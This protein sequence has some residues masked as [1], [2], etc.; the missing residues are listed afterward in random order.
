SPLSIYFH[1][2]TMENVSLESVDQMLDNYN[3]QE[4]YEALSKMERSSE[5]EW[6]LANAIYFLSNDIEDAKERRAKITEG[7][8]FAKSAFEKDPSNAEAAKQA[9]ILV[10][11]LSEMASGSLEQMK[12]GAQFKKYLD[13]TIALNPEPDMVILH[14]RGRFSFAVASLSW[15]ERTMACK[16]LNSL[17]SCTYDDAIK[18][19]LAAEQIFPALDTLLFIGKAYLGKGDKEKGREYLTRVATSEAVDPVDN[20]HIEEAKKI[21]GDI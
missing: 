2:Q 18:D 19:L 8:E 13:H 10:G 1:L 15:L 11:T 16:V 6:R 5:V 20:E 4:A 12:L 9:A 7:F 17:P 3:G 14:M 21:L